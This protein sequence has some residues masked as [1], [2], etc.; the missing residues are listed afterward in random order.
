MG[1]FSALVDELDVVG[2]VLGAA[3]AEAR[4]ADHHVTAADLAELMRALSAVDRTAQAGV[5]AAMAQFARR[6]EVP[7]PQDPDQVVEKVHTIG[8][9]EEFASTEVALILGISTR[10]ADTRVGQATRLVSRVPQVLA[11]VADGTIELGQAHRVVHEMEDIASDEDCLAVD[12]FVATRIGSCDQT[13]LS[14]LTRYAIGR[15]CP[16]ALRE[17]ASASLAD[18]RFDI[19]PGPVGLAEV[20]ALVPAAQAAALWEATAELAGE[21]QQDDPTLSVDQARADA[22]IDLAL[23]NV[24]VTARVDLGLPVVGSQSSALGECVPAPV[25]ESDVP[26]VPEDS[27]SDSAVNVLLPTSSESA[28]EWENRRDVDGDPWFGRHLEAV[29]RAGDQVVGLPFEQSLVGHVCLSGVHLPRVGYLPSDVVGG[30]V[31]RLGTQIGLALLDAETGTLLGST[32]KAYRPSAEMRHFVALRD[33]RCRMFG[34]QLSAAHWDVD[35]AVSHPRGATTPTNLA[36]LCRRH[37]RAKQRRSWRYLLRPDGVAVWTSPTGAQRVTY[38]EAH[39]PQPPDPPRRE[40][41]T[42]VAASPNND[43]PPF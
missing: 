1:R 16:Q 2:A 19:C 26:T 24:S 37:H 11:R 32:R 12:E 15:I 23:A 33:G 21:Y 7:D 41:G 36:G 6:E 31:S 30:L 8:F 10:S 29:D 42:P 39:L 4:S 17:R 43:P 22:F 5:V 40:S 18:R 34:C 20:Y 38:P 25:A 9:V 14:Q 27:D 35:H 3:F 13:R 28:E